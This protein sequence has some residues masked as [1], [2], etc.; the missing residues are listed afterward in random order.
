V[1]QVLLLKAFTGSIFA[2]TVSSGHLFGIKYKYSAHFNMP[3]LLGIAF[4]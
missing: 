2:D 3:S 1:W 4:S